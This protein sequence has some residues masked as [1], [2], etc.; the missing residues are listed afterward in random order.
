MKKSFFT[1]VICAVLIG[2]VS[3]GC[4]DN[5]ALREVRDQMKAEKKQKEDDAKFQ[6]DT[7]KHSEYHGD[8]SC[9][10]FVSC[11]NKQSYGK[12]ESARFPLMVIQVIYPSG[13]CD[14]TTG[15][16]KQKKPP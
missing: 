2:I 8:V 7:G 15:I 9:L 3:P 1:F 13:L 16:K 4:T 6:A 5:Q 10:S 14:L 12:C 11:Y